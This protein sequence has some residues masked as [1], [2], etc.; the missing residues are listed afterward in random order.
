[1]REIEPKV[2][3]VWRRRGGS[4]R[5]TVSRCA[6][7]SVLGPYTVSGIPLVAMGQV[8]YST[9]RAKYELERDA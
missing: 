9:L 6:R 8:R 7:R 2:G 1:V 5:I 4:G 3:Q